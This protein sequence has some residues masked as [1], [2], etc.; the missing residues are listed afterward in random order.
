[1]LSPLDAAAEAMTLDPEAQ[2]PRLAFHAALFAA[3]VFVWLQ[4][5]SRDGQLHPR[6]LDLSEGRAVLAFESEARL[7]AFAGAAVPYAA[8]PGRV[9]V[10]MLAGQG[11]LMLAVNPDGD[12]PALLDE[13]TLTW[14]AATLAA[15]PEDA[16]MAAPH[17]L[18]AL[19]LPH[20]QAEALV[21]ALQARLTGAPGLAEGVLA[22]IAWVDGAAL[23]PVL[24]LGGVPEPV[25]APLAR[26]AGEAAALSVAGT[27]LDV[28]FPD[29]SAM[30]RLRAVGR[31]LDLAPPPAPEPAAPLPPGMDPTR[32][33][34][35]R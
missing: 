19:P 29:D 18:G 33:P 10:A 31:I 22:G 3:E 11:G 17:A 2:G 34:R 8:L 7:A 28:I 23:T 6:I 24:A 30:A 4:E 35:L 16:R 14:A 26:A 15:A 12:A 13:A 9:L 20:A 25:Q 27:A 21:R 5:E 32:P 1:M